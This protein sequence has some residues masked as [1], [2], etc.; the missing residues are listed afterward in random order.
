ML[1][2]VPLF[3]M[4]FACCHVCE[5]NTIISLVSASKNVRCEADIKVFIANRTSRLTVCFRGFALLM[6]L[7]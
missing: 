1:K 5:A 6:R 2:L 3:E 4:F 7:L